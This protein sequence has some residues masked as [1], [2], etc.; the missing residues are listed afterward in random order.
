MPVIID[1]LSEAPVNEILDGRVYRKMS[2]NSRHARVQ[3]LL[4][5]ILERCGR[6][7]GLAGTEW[8][9]RV[10]VVDESKTLLVPD[11]AFLRYERLDAIAAEDRERPPV[12]PDVVVEVRSKGE[13]AAFRKRK[14]AKYLTCG[15]ALVLDI[16]PVSC[17][18]EAHAKDGVRTYVTGDRFE[19]PA[20]PWLV[21]DVGEAFVGL[22]YFTK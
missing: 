3:G 14:I 18:L 10:G 20:V 9:F 11:V 21:F 19:H 16:D 8:D 17:R 4:M 2:P 13:N 7:I 5:A 1:V 15:T 6:G 22:E 12:A